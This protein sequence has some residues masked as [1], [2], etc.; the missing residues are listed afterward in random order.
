MANIKYSPLVYNVHLH[1]GSQYL[2]D[3][4]E[5]GSNYNLEEKMNILTIGKRTDRGLM[6]N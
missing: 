6:G 4:P 5:L 1:D 2:F 3:L